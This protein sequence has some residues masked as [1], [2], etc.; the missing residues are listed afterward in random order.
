MGQSPL[1]ENPTRD[2]PGRNVGRNYAVKVLRFFGSRGEMGASPKEAARNLRFALPTVYRAIQILVLEGKLKKADLG[3]YIATVYIQDLL[4]LGEGRLGVHGLVFAGENYPP[5]PPL[6]GHLDPMP[7]GSWGEFKRD[8]HGFWQARSSFRGRH[9]RIQW[10][11]TT[12]TLMVYLST[13]RHPLPMEQVREFQAWLEAKAEPV[14]IDHLSWVEESTNIDFNEWT[15]QKDRAI[16]LRAWAN[17]HLSLYEKATDG[18]KK[19]RLELEQHPRNVSFREGIEIIANLDP[20]IRIA[21]AA[22]ARAIAEIGR[23]RADEER[24]KLERERLAKEPRAP[25]LRNPGDVPHWEAQEG[26]FG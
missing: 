14:D 8:E 1:D 4:R 13:S 24:A 23:A 17:G 2:K 19:L 5:G 7:L 15:F 22:E 10:W 26:G 21:K 3:H 16:R 12:G 9:A 18:R 25:P 6:A 20:A 11:P